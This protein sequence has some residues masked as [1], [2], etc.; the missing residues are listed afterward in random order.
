M[1][2]AL[3][4]RRLL[5]VAA[6]AAG[7][8]VVAAVLVGGPDR[9]G[10]P[11]TRVLGEGETNLLNGDQATFDG[12]VGGWTVFTDGAS[13]SHVVTP[14]RSSPGAAEVSIQDAESLDVW[15][16][17]AADGSHGT[18]ATAGKV[19]SARVAVQA[20]STGRPVGA[21][22]AFYDS[23]GTKIGAVFG[24]A[25]TD[26]GNAW[27]LVP[28]VAGL[29]P[30]GTATV[31]YGLV[32][33]GTQTNETH[34]IDDATITETAVSTTAVKGPL[35]VSG[36]QIIG[37][38]GQPVVLRGVNR[39]GVE[40]ATPNFPT[41]DEIGQIH[42]WGANFVR[43]FLNERRWLNT[44]T[45]TRPTNDSTYPSK[46]DSLVRSITSRGM[47]ALLD[48]HFNVTSICRSAGPQ[49]MADSLFSPKFWGQ[50]AKRYKSNPL[51]AFDLYNEPHD[52]SDTVWKLGGTVT[53][54]GVSFKVA[55]MQALYNA[56]RAQGANNLV[57]ISG[58]DW[59][60]RPASAPVVGS[61]I[62]NAAHAYTCSEPSITSCTLADPYDPSP[63]LNNWV[64]SSRPVVVTEFGWPQNNNGTY[65][66]NVISFARSRGW[67]WAA[68]A[69]GPGT[70]S[71]W[72][73][74]GGTGGAYEPSPAGIPV[75]AGLN[76]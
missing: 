70:E 65:I 56:V 69:F 45:S 61:N 55:G 4:S 16:A 15:V 44:C 74:V 40:W 71:P 10:S 31:V 43:V 47:V 60:D 75:L 22:E 34:Y 64:G 2:R 21:Y 67:G 32:F 9:V 52:I 38:D 19:Y 30:D 11:A 35:H 58:N 8:L 68:F 13:L 50:V 39:D 57:F 23:A 46:I 29:A 26:D 63:L 66:D 17:S 36:D 49:V 53:Y 7:L 33:Y 1:E 62:V 27:S 24:Q 25:L 14:S 28:S 59:A 18:P 48:L 42:A 41:D 20:G 12:S 54:G 3:P 5:A 72:S 76:N 6:L 73:L 37:S 51:V